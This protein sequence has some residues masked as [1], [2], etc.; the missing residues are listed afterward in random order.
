MGKGGWKRSYW[1]STIMSSA[2]R[3][4]SVRGYGRSERSG[5]GREGSR[6]KKRSREAGGEKR[7]GNRFLG[8]PSSL[9]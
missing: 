7:A 3:S 8:T 5:Q 4:L 1:V 2:D 6:G 9:S